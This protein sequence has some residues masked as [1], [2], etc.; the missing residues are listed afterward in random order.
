MGSFELEMKESEKQR[1]E[2][3]EERGMLE[4]S[5]THGD[6]DNDDTY[7]LE[8]WRLVHMSV[9]REWMLGMFLESAFWERAK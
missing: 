2:H 6:D 3:R 4:Y 9:E 8:T 5:T 7:R 1:K